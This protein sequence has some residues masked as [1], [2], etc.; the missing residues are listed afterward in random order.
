M[1]SLSDVIVHAKR[2][3]VVP[4]VWFCRD[5]ACLEFRWVLTSHEGFFHKPLGGLQKDLCHMD[6]RHI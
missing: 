2:V 3:E 4:G 1:K 6:L 5:V